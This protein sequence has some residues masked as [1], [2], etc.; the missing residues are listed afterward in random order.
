MAD[1]TTFYRTLIGTANQFLVTMQ[2]LHTMQDRMAQDAGL[3]A[4]AAAAAQAA[5]RADLTAADFNNAASAIVQLQFTLDTG[6]PPQ[7]SYLYKLL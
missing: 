6:S 5:G 4:A 3:A 7:K 2:Q 1:A